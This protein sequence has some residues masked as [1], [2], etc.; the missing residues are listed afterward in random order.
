[1]HSQIP[2][3]WAIIFLVENRPM[4]PPPPLSGKFHYFFLFYKPSLNHTVYRWDRPYR[5]HTMHSQK[6]QSWNQT[7]QSVYTLYSLPGDHTALLKVILSFCKPYR[8]QI[9]IWIRYR[10]RAIAGVKANIKQSHRDD[11]RCRFCSTGFPENQE[12]VEFCGGNPLDLYKWHK[13]SKIEN[14]KFTP[15]EIGKNWIFDIL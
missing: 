7:I 10:A 2:V 14:F 5:L 15:L 8:Q 4:W 6:I 3:F 9:I 12:Q 1:M 11:S 13:T